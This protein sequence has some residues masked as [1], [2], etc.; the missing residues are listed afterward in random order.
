MPSGPIG[1]E[2]MKVALELQPCCGKRSGIGNY[3]YELARRLRDGEELAFRG[4]LFNFLHR[5]DNANALFG[6]T[7][8]IEEQANM[9]YGV[10]RRICALPF[11]GYKHMFQPADLTIFFNYIVPPGVT[12][13]VVSVIYDM[14]YLRYPNTMERRN[15][16]RLRHGL[17]RSVE[18][19]DHIITISA[20]SK[21]EIMELMGIPEERISVVPCA[22]SLP[23]SCADFGEL[24]DRLCLQQ[25]FLLYIGTI[26]PRKNL[27]R[28]IRA[29]EQLKTECNIPHHLVLAG[30][31]GWGNKD[32][33]RSAD[34]SPYRENIHFIGFV[35]DEE[36][37]ALYSQADVF[38]FPSLYEG[39][40]MPPLEA[41]ARGCPVVCSC[42]ASLPEIVGEAAE[43]V[44]P[45]KET[46]IAY[47]IW[48][49]LSDKKLSIR[50]AE[51]GRDQARK[52]TWETSADH[53]RKICKEV[54]A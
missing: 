5:N 43:L 35:S 30:G 33:Y 20:F 2:R 12:G 34:T 45:L 50:L 16:A 40:G 51:K 31:K 24:A 21:K 1:S 54:L 18:R 11:L 14:T 3:T 53:L 13:K 36:K 44:D 39:F 41:M 29:F 37:S 48:K 4:N 46:D 22:P 10:Y 25:P 8:P 52:F 7:M 15:L 28:L 49:V 23:S 32:I 26:E 42:T 17:Y 47:G 9:P 27:T 38:V 6:I 19:S